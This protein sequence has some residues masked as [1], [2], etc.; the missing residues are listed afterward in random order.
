ME[1]NSFA[2][3]TCAAVEFRST[4]YKLLRNSFSLQILHSILCIKRY[5]YC[6]INLYNIYVYL[7]QCL[8]WCIEENVNSL[9]ILV[10]SPVFVFYLEN[11]SMSKQKK[12]AHPII[13]TNINL[14]IP[15]I[16]IT[17]SLDEVQQTLNKAVD[18]IVK[19]MKGVRQWSKERISKVGLFNSLT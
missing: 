9:F 2:L 10:L 15:N 3:F 7:Y 18:C 4:S 17:P 6:Y 19:V 13:K 5:I 1:K 8:V 11:H 12:G 14:S 16:I